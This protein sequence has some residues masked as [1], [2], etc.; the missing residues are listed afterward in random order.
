MTWKRKRNDDET[1]VALRAPPLCQLSLDVSRVMLSFL[2]CQDGC[3]VGQVCKWW[4]RAVFNW[5]TPLVVPALRHVRIPVASN[6][7]MVLSPSTT[8][9]TL[10]SLMCLEYSGQAYPYVTEL[11]LG[12][13]VNGSIDFRRFPNLCVLRFGHDYNQ[14]LRSLPPKLE[15]IVFGRLFNQPLFP[16]VFPC[17]LRDVE[18]GACFDRP[19]DIGVFPPD[20]T[21]IKFG[22]YFTQAIGQRVLPD[23][24]RSLTLYRSPADLE[25]PSYEPVARAREV[26]LPGSLVA[27]TACFDLGYWN[28]RNLLPACVRHELSCINIG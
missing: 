8:S 3:V 2:S 7:R 12:P 13:R 10:R 17:S 18:F 9:L 25:M 28:F 24:L 4:N 1:L 5:Y 6:G 27:L 11:C 19:V 20:V 15:H 26:H 22:L 23:N 14:P 21:S 16:G